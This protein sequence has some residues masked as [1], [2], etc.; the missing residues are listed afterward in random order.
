[1]NGKKYRLHGADII[2]FRKKKTKQT[3]ILQIRTMIGN[4]KERLMDQNFFGDSKK[5]T[6]DIKITCKGTIKRL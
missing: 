1:M 6:E 5:L 4:K 2:K 3:E